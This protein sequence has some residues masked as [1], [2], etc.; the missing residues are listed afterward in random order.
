MLIVMYLG[1]HTRLLWITFLLTFASSCSTMDTKDT[2]LHAALETKKQLL[3]RAEQREE[4]IVQIYDKMLDKVARA[5]AKRQRAKFLSQWAWS[6][7]IK[8]SALGWA[9]Y[10]AR[11]R[12][13]FLNFIFYQWRD[14]H[15]KNVRKEGRVLMAFWRRDVQCLT[16][17][18]RAWLLKA[19]QR[20]RRLRFYYVRCYRRSWD[21][22]VESIVFSRCTRRAAIL[23][24]TKS[25]TR[26]LR[27]T[28][29]EWSQTSWRERTIFWRR[30]CRAAREALR[31]SLQPD[32]YKEFV[33]RTEH[34]HGEIPGSVTL[35]E[36][37]RESSKRGGGIS[38]AFLEQ[39]QREVNSRSI[40]VM[41]T[42]AWGDGSQKGDGVQGPSRG[43]RDSVRDRYDSREVICFDK[44]QQVPDESVKSG[45]ELEVPHSSFSSMRWGLMRLEAC[46]FLSEFISYL[47][48]ILC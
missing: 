15:R 25:A 14:F 7:I 20:H 12:S 23:L 47:R 9:K 38:A 8:G 16:K 41:T 6:A 48:S 24:S 37:Q 28:L 45:R 26:C 27:T 43:N 13:L 3:L 35:N 30:H 34:V 10:H 5:W 19:K 33:Q 18:T 22:F 29:R 11:E 17:V 44:D 42:V 1:A 32:T 4:R 40:G 36:T 21:A 2:R 46:F 39:R 31:H